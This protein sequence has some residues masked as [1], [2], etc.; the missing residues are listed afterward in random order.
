MEKSLDNLAPSKRSAAKT[1]F[2]TLKI[3]NEAG[4]QLTKKK[5]IDKTRETVKLT[6]WNKQVYE[7]IGY[8]RCESILHFYTTDGIRAGFPGKN[9][10][11]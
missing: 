5:V 2:E 7:K 11:Q 9:K 4:G 8:V 6:D 10:L 1:L 3:L